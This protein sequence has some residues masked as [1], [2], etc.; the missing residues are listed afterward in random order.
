ML[1][2]KNAKARG[3]YNMR[4]REKTEATDMSGDGKAGLEYEKSA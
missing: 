2:G 3:P 1:A 4:K